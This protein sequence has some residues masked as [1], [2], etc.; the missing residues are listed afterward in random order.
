N[1]IPQ[2]K[3]GAATMKSNF[4]YLL[5]L[6]LTFGLVACGGSSNNRTPV[7]PPPPPPPPPAE[8]IVD[9][10]VANGNFT[11]LVAAL[12]ATGLDDTL[13]D[14]DRTFTVFAPTDAAFAA[15]GEGAV[16]A[17]LEDLPALENILLYH[18]IAGA[19][20]DSTAAVGLAGTTVEMANG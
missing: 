18:V 20:V 5:V 7:T 19:E 14:E 8:T 17:L 1:G 15:L 4:K 11:T 16:E 12:V 9:V 3:S 10:A 6:A 2:N 13:D